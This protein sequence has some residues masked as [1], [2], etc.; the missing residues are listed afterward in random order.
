MIASV[1]LPNLCNCYNVIIV[2][3]LSV[4]FEQHSKL[5]VLVM[6]Y[7]H[8]TLSACLDKYGILPEETSYGILHTWPWAYATCTSTSLQ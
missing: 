6:E 3:A 5:P 1:T 4:F 8:T 7:L 2:M